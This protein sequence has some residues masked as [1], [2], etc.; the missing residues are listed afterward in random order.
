MQQDHFRL[1]KNRKM[2]LKKRKRRTRLIVMPRSHTLHLSALS[3]LTKTIPLL[4]P[5][6]MFWRPKIFRWMRMIRKSTSA[7]KDHIP[8][9]AQPE[10]SMLKTLIKRVA[11]LLDITKN[12][13]N[14]YPNRRSFQNSQMIRLRRGLSKWEITNKLTTMKSKTISKSHWT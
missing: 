5:Y 4:F 10:V 8:I 7:V 3:I 11:I 13:I 6:L 1:P 9:K 12:I 2:N 14:W